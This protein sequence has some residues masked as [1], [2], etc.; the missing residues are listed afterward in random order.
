MLQNLLILQTQD[1]DNYYWIRKTKLTDINVNPSTRVVTDGTNSITVPT[2]TDTTYD[3]T[4][5]QSGDDAVISLEGSDNV[6]DDVTL[7]AGTYRHNCK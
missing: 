4:V 7:A 5:T 6:D 1:L 3:L 2:D